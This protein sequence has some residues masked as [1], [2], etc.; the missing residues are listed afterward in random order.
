MPQAAQ[1]PLP[2]LPLVAPL[3]ARGNTVLKDP[4][5]F[6]CFAEKDELGEYRV[7]KRPGVASF[8]TIPNMPSGTYLPLGQYVAV[9]SPVDNTQRILLTFFYQISSGVYTPYVSV[10]GAA[11]RAFPNP[12]GAIYRVFPLN[13]TQYISGDFSGGARFVFIVI[14]PYFFQYDLEVNLFTVPIAPGGLVGTM[15][16]LAVLDSTTYLIDFNGVIWG[17][18]LNNAGGTWDPLNTINASALPGAGLAIARHHAW[19]VAFKTLSTEFFYDAGNPVGSPLSGV[20][21]STI[22]WGCMD[23]ATVQEIEDE[24]Y[25]LARSRQSAAF[26]ASLQHGQHI[27]VSTPGVDR[28]LDDVAGPYYSGAFKDGGHLFY[29]LTAIDANLTLVYDIKQKLWYVWTDVNGNYWPWRS[30]ATSPDSTVYMQSTN[31]SLTNQIFQVDEEFSGDT[32]GMGNSLFI[33][34]DIYLQNYDAGTR[35]MKMLQRMD[36][37]ADQQ[38]AFLYT[39]Y[40]EDDYQTWSNYRAV[41]LNT[42]RPTLTDC[43]SFIRRAYHFRHRAPYSLRMEA[44]ELDMKVGT[45]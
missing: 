45:A 15:Y 44:V 36:F 24:L 34:V 22:E 39:R 29:I 17:S 41:D 12:I 16:G 18:P 13:A 23:G 21:N 28:L 10:N 19:I 14:G 8:A 11:P 3:E 4:K 6:N 40:S 25:W 43:G 2:R 38:P 20:P 33:P 35:R 32:D 27:Q 5:L 30:I 37:I 7:Y 31:N 1:S 42:K 26:V 9:G